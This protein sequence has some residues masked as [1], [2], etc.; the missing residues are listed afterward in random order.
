M[1]GVKKLIFTLAA[2]GGLAAVAL[3]L[4]F[5][6]FGTVSACAFCREEVLSTQVFYRGDLVLGVLT[7]KPAA[8]G[9]VLIVPKR[10]VERFEDLTAEEIGEIGD[11]IKKI[12]RAVRSIFGNADY[13]LLQ[14][15]GKGAGQ[16]VPHVHF[17]YLPATRFLPVRLFISPWLKP[18]SAEEMKCLRESLA[19]SF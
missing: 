16:S 1:L 10:H 15:N 14:K 2:F 17:H 13:A 5:Q 11:A 4:D 3:Q 7:H 8:P 9:H 19:R 6:K 18:L 12:D